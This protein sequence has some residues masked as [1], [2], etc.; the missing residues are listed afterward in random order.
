MELNN[1]FNDSRSVDD[2]IKNILLLQENTILIKKETEENKQKNEADIAAL[3]QKND[4]DLAALKQKNEADLAELK[5]QTEILKQ[6]NDADLATLKQKNESDL[7]ALKQQTEEN[8]QKNE[9]DLALLKKEMQEADKAL[10][11]E[12]LKTEKVLRGQGINAGFATETIL[13][14]GLQKTL[15]LNNIKYDTMLTNVEIKGESGNI[16]TE[17]D[18]ILL[19]GKYAAIV[20]I[21]Y[22]V[23]EFNINDFYK[24]RVPKIK[25]AMKELKNKKIQLFM[26]GQSIEAHHGKK[27]AKLYG[28]GLV[29]ADTNGILEILAPE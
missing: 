6:K 18:I 28:I 10:K 23:T 26:A 24:N 29:T 8:K 4:A 21:K 11:F 20:E 9:A 12:Q 2:I 15:T 13:I 3:K 1:L 27:L 14:N 25:Q 5:Q 22:R 17:S 7:A 19:N 16:L